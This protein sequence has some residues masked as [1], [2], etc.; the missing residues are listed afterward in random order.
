[1]QVEQVNEANARIRKASLS[2]LISHA[3]YNKHIKSVTTDQAIRLTNPM[4]KFVIEE[5]TTIE[6][7]VTKSL[8]PNASK[9]GAF[10]KVTRPG[11]KSN[12]KINAFANPG[13]SLIH[14]EVIPHFN[15]ETITAAKD[16]VA[17]T[18]AI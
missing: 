6:N 2:K 16:K 14:Q 8:I 11:K 13:A 17:P 4:H 7:A 10:K 1:K 5:G 3:L 12:R 18:L 15:S 9:S